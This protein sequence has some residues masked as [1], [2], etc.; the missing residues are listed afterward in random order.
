M[1][2]EVKFE[3]SI[4]HQTDDGIV[5][6][7][8]T[9]YIEK[10]DG[11]IEI[12]GPSKNIGL[13]PG[14]FKKVTNF[15]PDLLPHFNKLWTPELVKTFKERQQNIEAIASGRA[16][17][18]IEEAREIKRREIDL[19][20]E[21]TIFAGFFVEQLNKHFTM[22]MYDQLNLSG[23]SLFATMSPKVP[24]NYGIEDDCYIY[25]AEEFNLIV[26]TAT[27]FAVYNRTYRQQL[28]RMVRDS[29]TMEEVM[30]IKWGY[31]QLEGK[32]KKKLQEVMEV[33]D[34]LKAKFLGGN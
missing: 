6:L 16:P 19:D 9:P 26:F 33:F 23:L 3:V 5:S 11:E 12:V 25:T 18:T 17:Q 1:N 21:D 4:V 15:A 31:T 30:A 14:D 2:T 7:R 13:V 28:R 27:V 8:K 10:D 32:Y 20:C 29:K 22:D 24:F 34:P